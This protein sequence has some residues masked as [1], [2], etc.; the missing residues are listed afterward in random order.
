MGNRFVILSAF[1]CFSQFAIGDV[2]ELDFQAKDI[3]ISGSLTFKPDS[4]LE[5]ST[6]DKMGIPFKLRIITKAQKGEVAQFTYHL[7]REDE[8]QSGSVITEKR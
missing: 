3:S 6:N 4:P 1:L 2:L 5:I 7:T 8:K